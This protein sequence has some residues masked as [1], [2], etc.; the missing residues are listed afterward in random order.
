[1]S[2][3]RS[4]Y[5]SAPYS[6]NKMETFSSPGRSILENLRVIC[7]RMEILVERGITFSRSQYFFNE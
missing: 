7:L 5:G 3:Y 4:G 1:I 6:T 2:G